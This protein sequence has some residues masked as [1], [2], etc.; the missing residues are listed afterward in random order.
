[1]I[2]GAPFIAGALLTINKVTSGGTK[3]IVNIAESNNL[4]RTGSSSASSSSSL[5][6]ILNKHPNLIK[7]ILRYIVQSLILTFITNVIGYK[8]SIIV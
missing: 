2:I 1:M 7:V 5:F 8:S 4:E 3:V 6:L